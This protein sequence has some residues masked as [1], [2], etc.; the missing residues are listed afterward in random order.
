MAERG[1]AATTLRDV[2]AE[3]GVSP[4][5]LYRYFP[6]KQSVVL[7]LYDDLSARYAAAA[8]EMPRGRWRDRF[9]F[10]LRTSLDVL[11]PHRRALSA[12]VPLLV[13]DA[14]HGLFSPS[15]TFSRMR[16]QR[17]FHD[18]VAGAKDAPRAELIGPLGR[19]L[20]LLHL[21][22]LLWWLL[23]KSPRRR[24]TSGL[25]VLIE[26][27]MP[28]A[29]LALRFAPVVR[30]LRTGDELFREALFDGPVGAG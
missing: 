15:T 13:G 9:L 8:A 28:S 30:L 16:V 3:A 26:K 18:A 11:G 5:L 1:Y 23:D 20:Y 7:A 4:T 12:L 14:E 17:A 2:A 21:A 29:A 10:A 27:T 22:V 24:A 25:V 19:L 6:S